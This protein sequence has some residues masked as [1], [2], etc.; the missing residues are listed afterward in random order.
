MK[1]G[2]LSARWY[3]PITGEEIDAGMWRASGRQRFFAP[4]QQDWLLVLQSIR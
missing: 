4:W 3:D 2:L 1:G